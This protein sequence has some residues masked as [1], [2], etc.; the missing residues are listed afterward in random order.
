MKPTPYIAIFIRTTG[1]VVGCMLCVI[2]YNSTATY[3]C[4]FTVDGTCLSQKT[5]TTPHPQ[6]GQLHPF[7]TLD[8]FTSM[9]L[10]GMLILNGS[11]IAMQWESQSTQERDPLTCHC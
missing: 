11:D 2:I 4:K 3:K 10:I 8:Y 1:K 7:G 9:L 5:S 6:L